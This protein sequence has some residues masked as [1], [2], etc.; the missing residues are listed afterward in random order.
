MD[1]NSLIQDENADIISG[2]ET[3]KINLD[4]LEAQ[5]KKKRKKN[6]ILN[7]IGL[8]A[9]KIEFGILSNVN[10]LSIYYVYYL[11]TIDKEIS[12]ENSITLS[13]IL[14]CMQFSTIWIGGVL[15]E[16]IGIRLVIAISNVLLI[17]GSIGMILFDNLLAYKF[18]MVILGLGIGISGSITN[19]NTSLYIP[20]KKGL[21]NG[22]AN[23]AWTTSSS[24]F[25][26][27]AVQV[28]NPHSLKLEFD[29]DEIK[30]EKEE[31][32]KNNKT[33]EFFNDNEEDAKNVITFTII[34]IA[35]YVVL[36]IISIVFTFN[37]KKEDYEHKD[38]KEEKEKTEK[39]GKEEIKEGEGDKNEEKEEYIINDPED[40]KA[41]IKNKSTKKKKI[42]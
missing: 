36:S 7:I 18:M 12:K 24:L 35:C 16:Y 32:K 40:K 42:K 25:N 10:Y 33:I 38:E 26:F 19:A 39:E 41:I 14:C 23:I 29:E 34:A 27:I 9:Q 13:S 11:H 28:A 21:I 20:E 37:F 8:C 4:L 22:I 31:A 1:E 30:Q 17:L 2:D 3:T 15:K 5:L 6:R